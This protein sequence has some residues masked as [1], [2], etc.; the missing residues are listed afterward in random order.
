[1]NE[2]MTVCF[3]FVF[4]IKSTTSSLYRACTISRTV[5][6]LPVVTKNNPYSRIT[7]TKC[8]FQGTGNLESR[9]RDRAVTETSLPHLS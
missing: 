9:I 4:G 1:M 6:L 2:M 5:K 8:P 3:S 7:R